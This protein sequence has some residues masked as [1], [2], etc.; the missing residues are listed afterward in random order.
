MIGCLWRP[1]IIVLLQHVYLDNVYT[2]TCISY[3]V[4]AQPW[5]CPC[6]T[7]V[8]PQALVIAGISLQTA[9]LYGYIHCKL[10]G[11]K[12][13]SRV[14]SRVFGTADVPKSKYWASAHGV[15]QANQA[16]MAGAG[17]S[18]V[19]VPAE[20]RV[21]LIIHQAS[22]AVSHGRAIPQLTLLHIWKP[23]ELHNGAASKLQ[24]ECP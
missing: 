9:N 12:T 23:A 4:N 21:I 2:H 5:I 15:A 11:Q 3:I 19:S 17:S 16:L 10:G 8:C 6:W 13:I 18:Q 1:F 7:L 22:L 20:S 24:E 14:T